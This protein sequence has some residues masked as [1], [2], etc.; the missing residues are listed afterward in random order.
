MK[1]KYIE[2]VKIYYIYDT[3]AWSPNRVLDVLGE[4]ERERERFMEIDANVYKY[5]F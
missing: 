3:C 5:R 1:V 2:Y 4:K